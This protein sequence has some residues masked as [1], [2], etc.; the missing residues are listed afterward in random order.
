MEFERHGSPH[1]ITRG[2]AALSDYKKSTRSSTE[3]HSAA[4]RLPAGWMLAIELFE[5]MV[6]RYKYPRGC[7]AHPTRPSVPA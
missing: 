5:R 4:F 3:D 7:Q 1:P 6:V 2:A